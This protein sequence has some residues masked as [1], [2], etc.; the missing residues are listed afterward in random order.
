MNNNDDLL[1]M[2][3]S[4]KPVMSNLK[5]VEEIP[6]ANNQINKKEKKLREKTMS[7]E[8]ISSLLQQKATSKRVQLM[9]HVKPDIYAQIDE[10]AIKSRTSISKVVEKILEEAL[11]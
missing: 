7:D 3:V 6:L 8:I 9:A 10:I 4:D 11:K 5:P 2:I 1:N